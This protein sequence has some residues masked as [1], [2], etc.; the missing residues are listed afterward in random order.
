MHPFLKYGERHITSKMKERKSVLMIRA[1]GGVT[2]KR[3]VTGK[4][5]A[6]VGS[7][8]KAKKNEVNIPLDDAISVTRHLKAMKGKVQGAGPSVTEN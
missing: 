8:N 6:K 3:S 7:S 5:K 2:K 4:G 1:K